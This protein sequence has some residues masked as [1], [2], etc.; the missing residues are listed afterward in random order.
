[1]ELAIWDTHFEV[2]RETGNGKLFLINKE[3]MN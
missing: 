3:L 2:E 1:M